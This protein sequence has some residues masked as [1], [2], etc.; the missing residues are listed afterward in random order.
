M[1]TTVQHSSPSLPDADLTARLR[2]HPLLSDLPAETLA[3]AMADGRLRFR[4]FALDEVIHA[5][6]D[7]CRTVE[8]IL[9]GTVAVERLDPGG[10]LF[11]VVRFGPGEI[12]GGNLVFSRE[13][14]YPLGIRAIAAAELAILDPGSL[15]DLCAADR[16]FLVS[17]LEYVS[18]HALHLGERIAG[19]GR[20]TL[21]ARILAWLR[22][23]AARQGSTAVRLDRTKTELAAALGVERSSLSRE[24]QN[25]R[26]AGLVSYNRQSIILSEPER[27]VF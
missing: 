4:R 22:A 7:E 13:P 17:L 12:L 15:L 10:R 9:S 8:L 25:M 20:S 18:D 11:E 21:R 2:A 3:A 27:D 16:T 14:S 1:V 24:L 23:E 19:A 26:R 6:G 5:P